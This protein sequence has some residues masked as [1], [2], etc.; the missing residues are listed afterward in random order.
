VGRIR[1]GLTLALLGDSG[2]VQ[3]K[4][5]RDGNAG[6][7]R[8]VAHVLKRSGAPHA[9]RPFTP[10]GYDERQFNSPGFALPVGCLMRSPNGTFPQYHNSGDDLD[11]IRP[12][13]LADSLRVAAGALAVL[14][15][16]GVYINLNP[17]C[18]P[19]LGKRGIYDG[20]KGKNT[21]GDFELAL[22][23][24]LNFSDGAY[25]LLDIADRAD[26]AFETVR[27]AADALEGCGLLR[28]AAAGE[29]VL[30]SA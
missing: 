23:W 17:K 18:E 15:G 22:L 1:H 3:Y 2:Q 28:P 25:G 30:R 26:I 5:T 11:F 8:A 21:L 9:I 13:A 14:E 4:R 12:E 20:L 29:R 24:V 7:D 16:D 27:R 19:R 6:I 10:Y